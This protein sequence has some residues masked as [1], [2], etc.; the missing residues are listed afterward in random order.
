LPQLSAADRMLV[1]TALQA[2]ANAYAPYSG[3]AVGAAVRTRAGGIHAG[4][5]L[6]NAAY[7]VTLCAEVGALMAANG[8]GDFD[9][10]VIAVV[11]HRFLAPLDAAS[12]VTPCGRCRQMISEAAHL[13][14][15]DVRILC[16][17]GDLARIEESTISELLPAG[18]GP[19]SLGKGET[20]PKHR[21]MLR[22]ALA[23]LL[24][25]ERR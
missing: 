25:I 24:A 17:S 11:G 4:S 19:Q 7:G 2:S 10:E 14:R 22:V 6:E 16:C 15:H 20:W 13:S 23:D 21:Q 5:N 3:F 1:E 8:A 9:L 12:V 18:F